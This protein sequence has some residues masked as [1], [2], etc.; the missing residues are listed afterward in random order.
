VPRDGDRRHER[1]QDRRE[2]QEG[3]ASDRLAVDEN[4]DSEDGGSHSHAR[5]REDRRKSRIAHASAFAP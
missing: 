2:G 1:E 4:L 5:K 3:V